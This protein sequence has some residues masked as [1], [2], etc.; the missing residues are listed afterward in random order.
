MLYKGNSPRVPQLPGIDPLDPPA[1]LSFVGFKTGL[2]AFSE[3]QLG[4]SSSDPPRYQWSGT[5]GALAGQGECGAIG[6]D[7]S[8]YFPSNALGGVMRYLFRTAEGTLPGYRL[9]DLG[10]VATLDNAAVMAGQAP[11]SGLN[12]YTLFHRATGN[13]LYRWSANAMQGSTVPGFIDPD[14]FTGYDPVNE[15]D[16][17]LDPAGNLWAA[18]T[19]A[20]P[21][22]RYG[23]LLGAPGALTKDVSI[24]GSNWPTSHQGLAMNAA[25]D[26]FVSNY[27]TGAGSIRVANAALITSLVGAG[28]S[29]PVPSLTFTSADLKGAE[30]II[31]DYA[32]NLWAASFDTPQIARFPAAQLGVSGVITADIVLTG[33]GMLGDGVSN[34]LVGIRF[35]PGYGPLR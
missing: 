7:G 18:S 17:L 32:G 25:G 9:T 34:G 30:F 23:G 29:N 15:H 20:G 11:A 3:S 1:M 8:L 21:I 33:G 28:A 31:F 24:L 13:L 10:G 16:I 12:P 5:T 14:V 19:G 4:A 6:P 27:A 35:F 2:Y 26:L 22:N